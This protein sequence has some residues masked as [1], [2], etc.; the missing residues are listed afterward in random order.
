MLER[1]KAGMKQ[2]RRP[3]PHAMF[4]A[5]IPR[6][7]PSSE[8]NPLFTVDLRQALWARRRRDCFE[9]FT[10]KPRGRVLNERGFRRAACFPR[11][12]PACHQPEHVG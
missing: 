4:A 5:L 1:L 8:K 7:I 11:L 3:M 6:A 10:A 9:F 2:A 12:D